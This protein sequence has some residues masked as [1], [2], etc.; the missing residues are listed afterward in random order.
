MLLYPSEL[1]EP[2]FP[3]R[4]WDSSS[5]NFFA[6]FHFTHKHGQPTSEVVP[7]CFS[8][9]LG[10]IYLFTFLC[11]DFFFIYPNTLQLTK[12]AL[13]CFWG[14]I[15]LG[16]FYYEFVCS[17]FFRHFS[18][19]LG[20]FFFFC[21]FV[22]ALN[23]FGRFKKMMKMIKSSQRSSKREREEK[24]IFDF[25]F[26]F[27]WLR[28]S[29]PRTDGSQTRLCISVIFSLLTLHL[30]RSFT[31]ESI[32]HSLFKSFWRASRALLVKK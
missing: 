10:A 3:L 7:F 2:L 1:C 8:V 11:A 18:S 9:C 13:F 16:K 29:T 26:F 17:D 23:V 28:S 4:C 27:Y 14:W 22:L 24:N 6:V 31:I 30:Q 15:S 20:N 5:H 12:S 21:I 19:L 25:R 32:S